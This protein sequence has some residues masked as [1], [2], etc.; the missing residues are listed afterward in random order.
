MLDNIEK[1]NFK[2][3]NLERLFYRWQSEGKDRD[4]EFVKVARVVYYLTQGRSGKTENY[5][6]ALEEL[7][8]CR[9]IEEPILRERLEKLAEE[10]LLDEFKRI[11]I[12]DFRGR[13]KELKEEWELNGI[14]EDRKLI[15]N[16][17]NKI[18]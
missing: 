18:G 8:L 2:K 3:E 13:L 4:R 9:G 1:D 11:F 17:I 16:I 6:T 7:I 10:L 15:N 5:D 12:E 14:K